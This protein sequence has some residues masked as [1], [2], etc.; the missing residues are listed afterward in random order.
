MKRARP[1]ALVL[2]PSR[3]ALS[4]V[5][6]HVNA[7]LGSRLADGYALVHYQVGSEG[8]AESAPARLAR[9]LLS[10][11]ALAAAILRHDAAIVHVNVS[12]NAKAYW[13][14]L[15][16]VL[17]AKLCGARVVLQK[18]GGHLEKF[19][20]NPLFA[21]FVKATLRLPDLV[22]VLSQAELA[23]YRAFVP[24]QNVAAVPNG[25]DA[26]PYR[27]YN[28]PAA[29]PARPLKLLYLG[30]LA[31]GKGLA[32]S[33]E[34]LAL[35][36]AA[37]APA[38]LVIAGG[39]PE[40]ARLRAQARS[41]S[42]ADCVTFAGPAWG[43]YKVRLLSN[44]DALLLPSYSEGLP[45]ALLEAMAAGAVPIVTPVGAIPDVVADGVHGRLVPVGEAAAIA[46]AVVELHHDRAALLRMSQAARARVAAA[47]SL[48]RLAVDFGG[49]YASLAPWP[50]SQAG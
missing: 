20:R 40:E 47:Y 1:V 4:G 31:A 46:R 11:F 45:Y 32:E 12:L 6:T 28:R 24:G 29:D 10:P 49:L 21:R 27:R 15:A 30:R 5:T 42:L 39:G 13:R 41:L 23:A 50:A 37:G 19:A 33:L 43:D 38:T 36:R 25:I 16:H 34:A 2:G 44:A 9:L 3:D 8:R 26:E 7:L 48:E 35:A 17:A 22:V 18:H 14:D